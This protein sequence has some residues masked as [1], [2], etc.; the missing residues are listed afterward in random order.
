M[1]NQQTQICQ[2]LTQLMGYTTFTKASRRCTGKWRGT[3]DY[4]LILDNT[5]VLGI[6]NGMRWFYKTVEEH[7]N[8]LK[9]FNDNKDNILQ[10]IREYVIADNFIAEQEGLF[11]VIVKDIRV[12]T[13]VDSYLLWPYLILEVDGQTFN[14][15]ETGLKYAIQNNEI[16][17]YFTSKRNKLYTAGAVQAPTYIFCNVRFSHLDKLYK[18]NI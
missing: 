12:N 11:P 1:N 9:R 5:T 2:E 18:I 16:D 14:F 17:E 4:S 7:I 13:S 8:F 10:R 3:T 6:S 15:T